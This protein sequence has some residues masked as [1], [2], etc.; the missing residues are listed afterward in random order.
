MT[1]LETALEHITA[2]RLCYQKTVD[3]YRKKG[4]E[5]PEAQKMLDIYTTAE[6]ALQQK[7]VDTLKLKKQMKPCLSN[8]ERI[9]MLNEITV[10]NDCIRYISKKHNIVEKS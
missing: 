10:W 6:K 1:P 8:K 2:S 3:F 5:N 7:P 9:K 4:E